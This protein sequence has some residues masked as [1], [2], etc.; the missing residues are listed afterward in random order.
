MLRRSQV[1]LR[2]SSECKQKLTSK[3]RLLSYINGLH[4]EK[5]GDL[6]RIIEQI[7]GKAIPMWNA[8]F[9]SLIDRKKPRIQQKDTCY[10]GIP[11]GEDP[12]EEDPDERLDFSDLPVIQPEPPNFEES[13][14]LKHQEMYEREV[15]VD[16]RKTFGKLQI[17]VK[18]RVRRL[19][20]ER[21]T[22]VEKQSHNHR[23]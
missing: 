12:L 20:S 9:G 15:P 4:P 5:N 7:V 17:V 16:L 11:E 23:I 3:R 6:H 10:G 13:E 21:R 18:V 14:W 2:A 19:D 8:M 22:G 1:G